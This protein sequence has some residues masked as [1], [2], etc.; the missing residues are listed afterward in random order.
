MK[1]CFLFFV[2]FG[3]WRILWR[4]CSAC[5]CCVAR[6][7]AKY[8]CPSSHRRLKANLVGNLHS[9]HLNPS[10]ERGQLCL[11]S[12]ALMHHS[13]R[14]AMWRAFTEVL[15][16]NNTEY[17]LHLPRAKTSE[18]LSIIKEYARLS[19]FILRVRCDK[20]QWHV[21]L[22]IKEEDK[23]RGSSWL[24]A[25]QAVCTATARSMEGCQLIRCALAGKVMSYKVD[26]REKEAMSWKC[27]TFITHYPF[28]PS[29]LPPSLSPSVLQAV[30]QRSPF[31]WTL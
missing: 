26:I 31:V 3:L 14:A 11:F 30:K 16:Q 17:L 8:A 9:L 25:W 20:T 2:S 6:T 1:N 24:L 13:T 19:T 29:H 27:M 22:H 5:M 18:G 15:P 21:S 12:S 28:F 10:L 7:N 4:L 23:E